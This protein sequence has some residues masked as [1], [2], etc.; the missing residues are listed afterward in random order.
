MRR[1]GNV[2][3]VKMFGGRIIWEGSMTDTPS[4]TPPGATSR[5]TD[6]IKSC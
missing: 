6:K 1:C 5:I 4:D 3:V 2:N